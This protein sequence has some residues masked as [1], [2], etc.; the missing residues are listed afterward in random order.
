MLLQ[1]PYALQSV[2]LLFS[3]YAENFF[4]TQ[5]K[6][7]IFYCTE[8]ETENGG[9]RV[10]TTFSRREGFEASLLFSLV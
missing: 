1:L 3:N 10:I 5:T 8:A 4:S 2:N 9:P 7:L 6:Y